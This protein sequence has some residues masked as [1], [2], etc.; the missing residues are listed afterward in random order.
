MTVASS[1]VVI[2]LVVGRPHGFTLFQ[3]E[4]APVSLT[5]NGS[6]KGS[7]PGLASSPLINGVQA[8]C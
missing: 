1:S 2:Q 8:F 4:L 7:G 5:F 6:C 3:A